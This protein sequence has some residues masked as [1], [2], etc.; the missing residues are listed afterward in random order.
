[1][2][3]LG[4]IGLGNMGA[5]MAKRLLDRPGGLTVLDARPEAVEPFTAAGARVAGDPADLARDCDVVCVTVV[6][7]AQVRTVVAGLL[8]TARPGT[9]IA[10]HS[11]IAD[12]TAV[13]LAAE[14]A[15]RGVELVDAPVSGGAP[16]AEQG[17]LAVM[18]GAS[19]AAF[20]AV[21]EPFSRFADLV[22]HAG[23]V[24]A[25][26]RMK[27]ARNL[28]HFVSFTAAAEA[29]RLAEAAGLD[30]TAL[31]KVVRHTDAITGGAG[32]IMLRDTTAPIP[33]D[34]FW[35]PILD[36]VRALGE[37]DLSLALGLGA[38]LGVDLPLATR[39]LTGLG[40][41]LGVGTGDVESRNRQEE[42]I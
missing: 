37:K 7:D 30:I 10:V 40:P 25:G 21:R 2:T 26:T 23:P 29:Q 9:V 41:G 3:R 6:D 12:T 33:P 8:D 18:V 16:G 39:A 4:Y 31:G 42:R 13:E 5:P 32:A 28:L 11:T 20:D 15:D 35:F 27:L 19:D 22:V 36:H 14:C 38:R 17:R 24:G 1:M 34:D